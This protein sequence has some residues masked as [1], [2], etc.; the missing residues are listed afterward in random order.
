MSEP[1]LHVVFVE[2][3]IH[4]NTGNA[5]RTCLAVSAQL[6]LVGPLGFSLEAREVRRAGLDYWPKVDPKYYE[7]WYKFEPNLFSLGTPYFFSPEAEREYW[8]VDFGERPVL[9]FGRESAGFSPE[10]RNRYREHLVRIPQREDSIRS[11]NVSTC[12]GI[13]AYEILRQRRKIT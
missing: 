2:P 10:L 5:G 9:L 1:E 3:E 8:D 11:L 7:N 12:V 6:H 13:A 4:W